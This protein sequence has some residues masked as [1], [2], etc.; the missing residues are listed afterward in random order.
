MMLALMS[1][2]AFVFLIVVTVYTTLQLKLP[3]DNRQH[4]KL[5]KFFDDCMIVTIVLSAVA[6]IGILVY[7]G[8]LA[9]KDLLDPV[10]TWFWSILALI[11]TLCGIVIVTCFHHFHPDLI[12]TERYNMFAIVL[13][14]FF[15]LTLYGTVVITQTCKDRQNSS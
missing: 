11:Y 9:D 15:L 12:G 6:S 10:T 7:F 5:V 2:L 3:E 8:T 4:P 14:A 1:L 13:R